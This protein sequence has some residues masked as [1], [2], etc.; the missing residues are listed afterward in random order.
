MALSA[1]SFFKE[2]P[3]RTN[4]IKEEGI[5]TCHRSYIP[6]PIFG[7]WNPSSFVYFS[8]FS[9]SQWLHF[10]EG[11]CNFLNQTA[12]DQVK[13]FPPKQRLRMLLGSHC[14]FPLRE[15]IKQAFCV[16]LPLQLLEQ[17]EEGYVP[18]FSIFPWGVTS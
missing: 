6:P 4:G 15:P 8:F 2:T 11:T 14:L 3:D 17:R 12:E 13:C 5:Y 7:V 10:H 18:G 9:F 1:W 16:Q